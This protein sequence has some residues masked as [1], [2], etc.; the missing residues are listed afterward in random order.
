MA[1]LMLVV[2]TLNLQIICSAKHLLH[3]ITQISY[4]Y[5]FLLHSESLPWGWTVANMLVLKKVREALGFQQCKVFA[6]GA[7]PIKMDT[8]EFFMSVNI[9]IMNIYGKV[10]NFLAI[11]A[12]SMQNTLY[13]L[14]LNAHNV[15]GHLFTWTYFDA[16]HSD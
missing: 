13:C 10:I 7:A 3:I 4:Y 9:P 11:F 14:S 5:H 8:M 2:R 12:I 1:H 6:V 16:P 15:F